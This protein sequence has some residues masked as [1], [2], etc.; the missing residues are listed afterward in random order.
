MI[1]S[2]KTITI[3][4]LKSVITLFNAYRNNLAKNSANYWH[5]FF[6]VGTY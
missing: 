6:K 1:F 4:T 2:L 3:V 5:I